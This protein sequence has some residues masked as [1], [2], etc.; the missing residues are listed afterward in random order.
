ML[1]LC[2]G[3]HAI[4]IAGAHGGQPAWAVAMEMRITLSMNT[5]FAQ[6]RNASARVGAHPLKR[7]PML[8][9]GVL[10][11]PPFF[12]ATVSAFYAMS[13]QDA[14]GLLHFYGLPAIP[15]QGAGMAAA[16]TVLSQQLAAIAAYIGLMLKY[17]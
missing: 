15:A 8:V 7:L 16:Q 13:S 9:G 6:S 2:Y 17:Y 11:Y 5:G 1:V 10:A 12:P 4:P 14:A 3:G